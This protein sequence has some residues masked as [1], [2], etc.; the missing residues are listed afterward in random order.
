[1]LLRQYPY[2]RIRIVLEDTPLQ[3][4][5][6]AIVVTN[7]PIGHAVLPYPTRDRLD[8][9]LLGVYGVRK[10]PLWELPR[11]ALRL[12]QGYWDDDP[13]IFHRY[14]PS[15][16]LYTRH[17]RRL[18]VMND[19]ERLKITTPLHYSCKPSGLAVLAP[20]AEAG[21]A[22]QAAGSRARRQTGEGS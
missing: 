1:L 17:A 5:T 11:L 19:G 7:N 14:A 21:L 10:G 9:G 18:T 3:V 2:R 15:L 4:K 20:T 22:K 6:R 16:S 13:R 12:L 8:T